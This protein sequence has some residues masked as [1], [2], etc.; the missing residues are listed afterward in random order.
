MRIG[1][2]LTI[3]RGKV[4]PVPYSGCMV[5][6]DM[7]SDSTKKAEGLEN[8]AET[9][10]SPESI[11]DKIV[12]S[13]LK[14]ARHELRQPLHTLSLITPIIEP[15]A[16]DEIVKTH[17]RSVHKMKFIM[18]QL[19]DEVEL[20][21]QAVAELRVN[22]QK[23]LGDA[24]HCRK[25]RSHIRVSVDPLPDDCADMQLK[26][27][28][29]EWK[30]VFDNLADNSCRKHA[31]NVHVAFDRTT[32]ATD[33]GEKPALRILVEDDGEGIEEL[34]LQ[35]I[36]AGISTSDK[37]EEEAEAEQ[38]NPDDRGTGLQ[39]V[40]RFISRSGG[41]MHVDSVLR[42]D[43]PDRRYTTTFSFT[44]PFFEKH[45][46]A[47]AIE[48]TA[49]ERI[50]MTEE[51]SAAGAAPAPVSRFGD[52]SQEH[53]TQQQTH[54]DNAYPDE[55]SL[56][57]AADAVNAA[58]LREAY[59]SRRR[60]MEVIG[61]TAAAVTI[62]GF[63]MYRIRKENNA[64]RL[65]AD[66]PEEPAKDTEDAPETKVEGLSL[67]DVVFDPEGR[68]A[69]FTLAIDGK[70]VTYERGKENDS[71]RKILEI[72]VDGA[73]I[74]SFSVVRGEKGESQRMVL[75][76]TKGGL[77]GVLDV[78]AAKN[79]RFAYLSIPREQGME[80]ID[81]DPEKIY[82]LKD[83]LFTA[84][85]R[86]AATSWSF[87]HTADIT[88]V[89]EAVDAFEKEWERKRAVNRTYR[90]EENH[91]PVY[92]MLK[93]LTDMHAAVHMKRQVDVTTPEEWERTRMEENQF[94][95]LQESIIRYLRDHPCTI[96]EAQTLRLKGNEV[97]MV[98]TQAEDASALIPELPSKKR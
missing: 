19:V 6:R 57:P 40:R 34:R 5:E 7:A 22:I 38:K 2:L 83:A 66:N 4:F 21:P 71:F 53:Q 35:Q 78:S 92:A 77:A 43:H 75:S 67:S 29:E 24:I 32:L 41:V 47:G 85:G 80:H 89:R 87:V 84:R 8:T 60:F 88:P 12:K 3:S 27:S 10:V 28:L 91:Q 37:S 59:V 93:K 79:K 94:I 76:S 63:A 54:P 33:A 42:L 36:N 20:T 9:Q 55:F 30:S 48:S 31:R 56:S 62:G 74:V 70:P 11:A 23:Y 16:P 72:D 82:P 69:S 46:E 52:L 44:I 90:I 86:H 15:Y 25:E 26:T 49:E 64:P 96:E 81:V 95:V 68:I 98:D 58:P 61:A 73:S 17:K 1:T 50:A 13:R 51:R 65:I 45:A 97:C 18:D 14:E 39:V